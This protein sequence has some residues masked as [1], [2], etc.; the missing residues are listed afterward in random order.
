MNTQI[1]HD[2][3]LRGPRQ[4]LEK[5][6]N[7]GGLDWQGLAGRFAAIH[8]YNRAM[9]EPLGDQQ[10]SPGSFDPATAFLLALYDSGAAADLEDQGSH[11]VN[12]I[13]LADGKAADGIGSNVAGLNASGTRGLK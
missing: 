12:P 6:G 10:A 13:I 8:A 1:E 2:P 7:G 3:W 9:A 11:A 4:T 5:S